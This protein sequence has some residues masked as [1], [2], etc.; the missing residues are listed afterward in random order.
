MSTCRRLAFF[1]LG[2][3]LSFGIMLRTVQ[4]FK[5]VNKAAM[6]VAVAPMSTSSKEI[7][8]ELGDAF[9]VHSK[10]ALQISAYIF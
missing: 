10:Y 7:T 1:A 4:K 9:S 3:L 5:F 6:R 8:V 2:K